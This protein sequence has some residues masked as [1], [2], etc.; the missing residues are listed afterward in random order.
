[1]DPA[2]HV[3][4]FIFF[5]SRCLLLAVRTEDNNHIW[6]SLSVPC[7]RDWTCDPVSCFFFTRIIPMK[8]SLSL[9]FKAQHSG[10]WSEIPA[11]LGFFIRF[12]FLFC[13]GLQTCCQQRRRWGWNMFSLLLSAADWAVGRRLFLSPQCWKCHSWLFRCKRFFSLITTALLNLMSMLLEISWFF[14]PAAYMIHFYV[15]LI[16]QAALVGFKHQWSL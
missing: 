1:M 5:I 6:H 12:F 13:P 15:W 9:L 7:C 11:P 16:L 3:D 4:F 14:P 8:I 10:V 2:M